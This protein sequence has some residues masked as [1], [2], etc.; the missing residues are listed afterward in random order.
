MTTNIVLGVVLSLIF[1]FIYFDRELNN[2]AYL[3]WYGVWILFVILEIHYLHWLISI[4]GNYMLLRAAKNFSNKK[5]TYSEVVLLLVG[6][7]LQL[8]NPLLGVIPGLYVFACN[9]MALK[10][11]M[12]VPVLIAWL[13]W[14]ALEFKQ[15]YPTEIINVLS[16]TLF[17]VTGLLILG[18]HLNRLQKERDFYKMTSCD[19]KKRLAAID[20]LET[21]LLEEII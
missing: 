11:Y 2:H 3:L 16:S 9:Y 19:L 7:L 14:G 15:F 21:K 4:V 18:T 13:G 5:V 20:K 17:L 6:G 12:K 1:F 8:T 10:D